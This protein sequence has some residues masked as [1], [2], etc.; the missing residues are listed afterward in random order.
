VGKGGAVGFVRTQLFR[1][2]TDRYFPAPVTAP[3]PTWKDAKA[4][5]AKLVGTYIMNR[6]ADSNFFR[7]L[8]L[9]G[10]TKVTMDKDGL[11]SVSAFK[12]APGGGV[13]KWREVGPFYWQDVNGNSRMAARFVD[14][15][16]I[17]F[18]SDDE[19]PVLLFQPAPGWS[20]PLPLMLSWGYILL[21]VLLWPIT[22]W[23]RARYG[24]RFALEGT[25]AKTYRF[26]RFAALVDVVIMALWVL[27]VLSLSGG[28]SDA[29]LL[30]AE[31]A[32]FLSIVAAAIGLWNLLVVW[33][34]SGRSWFGKLS[35][36]LI[37]IAL[38]GFVWVQFTLHLIGW[39]THY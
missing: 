4:D 33:R 17:G 18:T 20:N 10:Q 39:S 14:G 36:L 16:L 22:A 32:G 24:Q 11:L 6:R 34:D 13:R 23:V 25:A 9:L 2:F 1:D 29:M 30:A 35:S 28:G 7:I 26:V 19:P 37:A 12:S 15:R 3:L 5:G 31:L 21:F 27:V 38:V 8:S